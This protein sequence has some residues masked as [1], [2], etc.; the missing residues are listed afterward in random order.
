MQRRERWRFAAKKDRA[1]P[2]RAK[3]KKARVH[4]LF[5]RLRPDW[6]NPK[7]L[8]DAASRNKIEI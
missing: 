5:M 7:A 8:A 4:A 2:H 3:S 6:S 1:N